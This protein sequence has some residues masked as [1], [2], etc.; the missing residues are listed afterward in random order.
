VTV[1]GKAGDTWAI[2]RDGEA[3]KFA[4]GVNHVTAKVIIPEEIAWRVVTKGIPRKDA[5]AQSS[6]N[7]D[8]DLGEHV[9]SMLAVMA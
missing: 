6:I 3:W 8:K 7:G 9:F 5:I 2:V 1:S 4:D